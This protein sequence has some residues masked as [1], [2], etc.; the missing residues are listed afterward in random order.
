MQTVDRIFTI[1]TSTMQTIIKTF[2]IIAKFN[3]LIKSQVYTNS[4]KFHQHAV[5]VRKFY[6]ALITC[7]MKIDE[8]FIKIKNE[9]HKQ[10]HD[11]L[12]RILK[13]ENENISKH[14]IELT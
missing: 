4:M 7:V 6:Q 9:N 10:H 1:E 3:T 8:N 12:I 2:D 13:N 5:H 11:Q 14:E